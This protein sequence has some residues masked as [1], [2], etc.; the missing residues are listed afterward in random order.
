MKTPVKILITGILAS[1]AVMIILWGYRVFFTF[2]NAKVKDLITSISNEM[3]N[4]DAAYNFLIEECELIKKSK[5][6]TRQVEVMAD[7]LTV[8]KEVA[9][10][11]YAYYNCVASGLLEGDEDVES[12][13]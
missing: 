5:D 10:V 12:L 9:L 8:D 2:N 11:R 6:M 7:L 3:S 1:A 4:P 13:G